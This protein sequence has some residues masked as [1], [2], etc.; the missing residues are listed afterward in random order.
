MGLNLNPGQST[1]VI[2]GLAKPFL[3]VL[4]QIKNA[5]GERN[6]ENNKQRESNSGSA[7]RSIGDHFTVRV[8]SCHTDLALWISVLASG[9]RLIG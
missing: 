5:T 9:K 7:T 3:G 4:N 6:E 1:P 8:L 2:G